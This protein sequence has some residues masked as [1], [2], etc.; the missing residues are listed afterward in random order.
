MTAYH[1]HVVNAA[2]FGAL[3][4]LLVGWGA[5]EKV[6]THQPAAA[7]RLVTQTRYAT[8]VHT[9]TRTVTI[10]VKGRVIRRRDHIIYVLVPRTVFHTRTLPRRRIVVPEHVVRVHQPPP[11]F[12]EQSA[13]TVL[14]VAPPPV[15]V[16]APVTVTVPVDVP[17]PTTTI[18]ETSPPLTIT[19]PTT[20]TVTCVPPDCLP[21]QGASTP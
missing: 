14:G 2:V 7:S 10:H 19:V 11:I 13:A 15:T 18:T 12:G 5:A 21:N 17:G 8:R 1:R 9:R 6:S 16:F 4:L 20:I 3:G